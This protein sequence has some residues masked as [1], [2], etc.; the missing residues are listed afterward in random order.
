MKG[1]RLKE[2][3]FGSFDG[4]I[5]SVPLKSK[6]ADNELYECTNM[7]YNAGK[8]ATRQGTAIKELIALSE[9]GESGFEIKPL[10]SVTYNDEIGVKLF[11]VS[12]TV[13]GTYYNKIFVAKS[14][15]TY[16]Y[17]NLK[18]VNLSDYSNGIDRINC[19]SFNG[20]S[21]LM[22][23]VFVVMSV[24]DK[25]DKVCD[26][27]I[28][29]LDSDLAI[30]VELSPSEIYAPLVYANG[31]G[32][33]YG[34]LAVSKRTFPSPRVLED[35][36]LLSSAFRA[37]YTTDGIS[38]E[39]YL[40][41][42]NL[43]N[44]EGENIVIS[45]TTTSGS[46]YTWTI[47]YN[48]S[49][50][51]SVTLDSVEYVFSINRTSGKLYFRNAAGEQSALPMSDGLYNNL[52][53]TAF[54][55]PESDRV[56]RMTVAESFNSRV[57]VSGYAQEGNVICFSKRNNPL[58]FPSSNIS[59]FGDKTGN[60]VAIKQQNDRLVLFKP[61]QIGICSSVSYSEYNVDA[62]LKGRVTLASTSESMAVKTI[63][64]GVGCVY[65]D[66]ILNCANRLVFLGSDRRVYTITSSSN[67]LQ[68]F[69][70]ISDKIE[71]S[72]NNAGD[73]DNV[74]A[75]DYDGRYMLFIDDNCYNFDYNST[76]F[77]SASSPNGSKKQ[78]DNIAW[79]HFNYDF[80]VSKPFFGMCVD[81]N[82]IVLAK[83]E[84]ENDSEK[85]VYYAFG[86]YSDQRINEDGKSELMG[87]KSSFT[88]KVSPF[89]KDCLK[90]IVG[91]EITFTSDLFVSPSAVD[92]YYN[93]ENK[94]A[95]IS[96]ITPEA[97]DKT[98]IVV[99]KT[100]CVFGVRHFGVTIARDSSFGIKQ[101]KVI[102]KI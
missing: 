91:I 20:K 82:P 90:K 31:R 39:F 65:P 84:G 80:G 37:S 74:F 36:N 24:I 19:F 13:G 94:S 75:L 35:F 30:A 29:E 87:I 64:T 15:Y 93:D 4:G 46:T 86:G 72:L 95:Y 7:Y 50:S 3:I 76:A 62:V 32:E 5:N 85:I 43:S 79:Y 1:N 70:R 22:G 28:F 98:E 52:Q 54:R 48:K 38:S 26:K 58:Y 17:F 102:Y 92:V 8:L 89:S 96:S 33:S 16:S 59:Y 63:N 40:P 99:K 61:H 69:Y 14:D 56:F 9:D 55:T 23:G 11:L 68:R 67:Y 25:Q 77:L 60:V 83:F 81:K 2:F 57:F 51:S 66:T 45:Y 47:P 41:A 73:F 101:I 12:R 44:L 34:D 71:N 21:A 53:V 6:I 78:R 97:N 18:T 88:T 100:P 42:K 49:V 10:G 27:F